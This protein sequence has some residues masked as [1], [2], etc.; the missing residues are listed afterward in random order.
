MDTTTEVVEER[1]GIAHRDIAQ[2]RVSE[3]FPER[4]ERKEAIAVVREFYE[5][6]KENHSWA[7]HLAVQ[8]LGTTLK[9]VLDAKQLGTAYE[10]PARLLVAGLQACHALRHIM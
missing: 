10:L 8:H 7:G 5:E 9:S 6:R 2:E 1:A 3:Q 4:E